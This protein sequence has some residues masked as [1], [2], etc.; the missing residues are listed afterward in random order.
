MAEKQSLSAELDTVTSQRNEFRDE[1]NKSKDALRSLQVYS[2]FIGQFCVQGD[3]ESFGQLWKF[4]LAR[5][6]NETK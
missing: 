2:F 5:R 3:Y 6:A 1:S 4:S